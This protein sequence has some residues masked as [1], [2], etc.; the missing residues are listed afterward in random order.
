MIF[1]D[2]SVFR[3][4]RADGRTRVWRR[5]NERYANCNIVERGPYGGRALMVWAGISNHFKTDL[6]V[7]N[8]TLTGQRYI[9]QVIKPSVTKPRGV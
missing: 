7:I 8:G 3:L 1:T 6:V 9:D 5:K 4:S 2:E